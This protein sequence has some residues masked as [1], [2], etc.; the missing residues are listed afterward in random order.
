M[1]QAAHD[2]T[3]TVADHPSSAEARLQ[4]HSAHAEHCVAFD[5]LVSEYP[6]P[7]G[8]DGLLPSDASDEDSTAAGEAIDAAWWHLVQT[9]APLPRGTSPRSSA[10]CS[11][12]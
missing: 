7:I 8:N 9:R 6:A 5:R 10:F 1:P 11:G 3:T 2:T 12:T 4:S